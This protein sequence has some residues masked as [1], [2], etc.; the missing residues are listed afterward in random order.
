M[1]GLA[2]G[3]GRFGARRS[4][5]ARV[6]G[7]IVDVADLVPG[8][9]L[10]QFMAAGPEAWRSVHEQ[11]LAR[12]DRA[13]AVEPDALVLPFE[14]ADYVDF[15]SSEHHAANLGGLLRPGT[16]PLPPAWRHLPIGYHG[17]SA[18]IVVS[19][20]AVERPHGIVAT[21]D[22]PRFGPTQRLD[23]E[24]EVGFVVGVGGRRIPVEAAAEH[25]FG[26]VLVND[27]SARD[28]QAFEYQPLGP[29]L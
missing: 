27:W 15:Y 17:R 14:V 6:D 9:S 21:E 26:A 25:V 11:V 22:G 8:P 5:V 24:V 10:N 19:G 28:V 7:R 4:A 1:T 29:F 12:A 3:V 13:E 16:E 20:T 23:V 18:T 2:Y